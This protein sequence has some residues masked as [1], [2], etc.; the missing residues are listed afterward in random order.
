MSVDVA[1]NREELVIL[2]HGTYA[3][4]ESDEG[5]AWWQIGSEPWN[6]FRQRLPRHARLAAR[7]EVFH[8]SGENSERER[9]KAA[10]ELLEQLREYEVKQQP[11][12]LVGH[13]HGGSVIWHALRLSLVERQ[14]L[15]WLK[16][17][18]TV[19]TP[20][21]HHRTR[22]VW[23]LANILNVVI[24][25]VLFRPAYHTFGALVK[26][27]CGP[28]LGW[29]ANRVVQ[30]KVPER[31]TFLETPVLRVFELMGIGVQMVDGDIRIGSFDSSR[32]DSFAQYLVSS[33]EGWLM[34]LVAVLVV[35]VYVNLGAFCLGPVLES[36]W[37]RSD[38]RLQKRVMRKYRDRW[39]GI[40]SD[41]D[42]AINGLRATLN[43]S[44]SI[45]SKM[46]PRERILFSDYLALISRPYFW[47][48]API[49]NSMIRPI[50]DGMI[51]SFLVKS[52]QGNNR[53]AAVVVDVSPSPVRSAK[54]Q[55]PSL[56]DWLNRGIVQQADSH[57]R[58][59]APKLR[60]LLAEPSFI[61]GLET[62]GNAI[63]GRELV[64]TSYFEHAAV[65]DLLAMHVAWSSG[66]RRFADLPT[67]D[68]EALVGWF[69][70][71]KSQLSN[72]GK[73]VP[74]KKAYRVDEPH[75]E[76]VQPRR[77]R[78]RSVPRQRKIA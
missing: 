67:N 11:Y 74:A 1:N 47:V 43:M 76:K 19:G 65:L 50:L 78:R 32:G 58:D 69:L 24:A 31:L 27:L 12:H 68:R 6:E 23:S 16:S 53:P 40:W 73:V 7:G 8:W 36:V 9:I 44:L 46:E 25:I 39:L 5:D 37:M 66:E 77:R 21:L 2:V 41:D 59:I 38:A 57:A 22:D 34:I 45:V 29:D 62:F 63:S 75:V 30:E 61:A 42:E 14:Q 17:W 55:F 51:R 20:F 60:T 4:N 28:W 54:N 64:H 3:A 13:S 72:A 56:P 70:R 10:R 33:P 18:S 52:A 15:N 48:F 26:A 71:F 35:Y 49:Y